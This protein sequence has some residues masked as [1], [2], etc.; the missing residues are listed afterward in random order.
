MKP[1]PN[2]QKLTPS[3]YRKLFDEYHDNIR[4]FLYFKTSNIGMAE[5][6]TQ[7]T[8]M[9]LWEVR[10][11]IDLK[12][13]KSFLYTVAGN[14]AINKLKR[15]QLKYKFINQI[16]RKTSSENP[17]F[18]MEMKEYDEKLQ[19][20]LELIPEGNRTVF[21]MNRIEGLK[22]REIAE[23]LGIGIKAV[24]KRMSKALIVIREK[25]GVNL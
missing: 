18:I 15:Q 5:D 20:I 24:E 16:D 22:Y 9:K 2:Y 21:L 11:K 1:E 8:F 10:E 4:N 6:L 19:S 17:E 13:V 25:L 14:L 7:D 3:D 23:R 12:T